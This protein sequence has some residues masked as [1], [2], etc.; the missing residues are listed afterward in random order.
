MKWVCCGIFTRFRRK[1]D[2]PTF[3]VPIYELWPEM[4][5]LDQNQ[6]WIHLFCI[7]IGICQSYILWGFKL[8]VYFV[9][10]H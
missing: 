2:D 5:W 7:L 9:V 8:L 10:F 1:I 4:L 3:L 6:E